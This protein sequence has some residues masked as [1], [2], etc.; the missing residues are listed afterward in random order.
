[1]VYDQGSKAPGDAEGRV[2]TPAV[3]RQ[4]AG[5]SLGYVVATHQSLRTHV[6]RTVWTYYWA[7]AHGSPGRR[8]QFDQRIEVGL[9]QR[10]DQP[11]RGAAAGD[12]GFG[13]D[14]LELLGRFDLGHRLPG[15]RLD[16][17]QVGAA[18]TSRLLGIAEVPPDREPGDRLPD[19]VELVADDLRFA[20]REGHDVLHGVDLRLSTG[21]RLAIV[22]PSGSGKSTLG[23]LLS[24]INGPR[25]GSVTVGDTTTPTD[26]TLGGTAGATTAV[27]SEISP[28]DG[29][30]YDV[31]VSGMTA[32]GS[33][34]ADIATAKA[35]DAAGNDNHASTSTDNT[36]TWALDS[37]APET[38]IDGG[39]SDPSTSRSASFIMRFAPRSGAAAGFLHQLS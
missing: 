4:I 21:E 9:A 18:S 33:I 16:R 31:A 13:D 6:P 26:V 30:R 35:T 12:S 8:S 17:L 27:V 20:Y 37:S 38:S 11:L 29:T 39:P 24:G 28:N 23:R 10:F 3:V 5:P 34:S 15:R 32:D 14:F 22:G 7:L 1:M 19:G 36:V 2:A 25:T